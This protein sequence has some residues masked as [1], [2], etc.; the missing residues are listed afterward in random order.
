MFIGDTSNDMDMSGED[1]EAAVPYIQDKI[2]L[3]NNFLNI[4]IHI[5]KARTLR[6]AP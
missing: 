2:N 6:Y 1:K 5:K 3:N 4:A